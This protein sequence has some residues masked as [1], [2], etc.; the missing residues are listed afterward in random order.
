VPLFN[1]TGAA[2]AT[3]LKVVE[4][5]RTAGNVVVANT[6]GVWTAVDTATD[7][8]VTGVAAGDVLQITGDFLTDTA[9]ALTGLDIATIVAGNPVNWV[10]SRSGSHAVTTEGTN[11]WYTQGAAGN[12]LKA[13]VPL[14]YPVVAG[15]ISG[16]NVT[17]RLYYLASGAATLY[18][19]TAHPLHWWATN[20]KH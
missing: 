20:L 19:T 15:D 2:G 9:A 18:A 8:T 1:P 16:G 12:Y 10:S 7:L 3:V 14:I 5:S 4:A 11:G 13:G 6:A 17:L